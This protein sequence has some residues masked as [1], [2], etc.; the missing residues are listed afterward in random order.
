MNQLRAHRPGWHQTSCP[1]HE[2]RS[3]FVLSGT[4]AC[5]FAGDDKNVCHGSAGEFFFK[6]SAKI[7]LIQGFHE[8]TPLAEG[9]QHLFFKTG[10]KT[11][12]V[13]INSPA[14]YKPEN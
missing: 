12:T 6:P 13:T 8:N 9:Q 5:S 7:T 2:G 3:Y 10:S 4:Y 1:S 14:V 11:D